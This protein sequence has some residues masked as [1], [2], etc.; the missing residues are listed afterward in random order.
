MQVCT[1]VTSIRLSCSITSFYR[2]YFIIGSQQTLLRI[3]VKNHGTVKNIFKSGWILFSFIF[4]G[5]RPA[6]SLYGCQQFAERRRFQW[7]R[8][9]RWDHCQVRRE[10]P[11]VVSEGQPGLQ[12]QF[13]GILKVQITPV[14]RRGR[15]S[16][17]SRVIDR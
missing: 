3:A 5:V 8:C 16:G 10:V 6:P 4:P 1:G 14:Q 12:P 7:T 13:R 15:F 11:K 17:R 2:V 9:G